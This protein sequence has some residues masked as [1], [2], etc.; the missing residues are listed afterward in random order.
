MKLNREIVSLESAIAQG[1][2]KEEY[3]L[4][5][6]ML[7]RSPTNVE[8]GIFAVMWSEHCSYKSSRKHLK[9]FPTEGSKVLQGP[10]ENAGII[11]IGDGRAVVFKME[12]HN[13]PSYIEPYQGAATGIGGILRDIFTMGARPVALMDFLR[14]GD[15][16]EPR[17][18]YLL[19]GVVAGIA[20][21]G[22]CVGIPTVGGDTF[23]HKT[24][25]GNN[26]VNVFCLGIV[27]T[28]EIYRGNATGTGNRVIYLGSKTGRDGIHGA[29]MASEEFSEATEEKRPTVQVGD[30]FTK[31]L[32][33]EACLEMM[34]ERLIEGIQDMGAAGLT[35]STFEMAYR[36]GGGLE[37]NLDL[38]PKREKEMT[39][40]ELMLS[41]SQ[42]RM[43]LVS[44]KQNV[45]KIL[46]IAEKWGLDACDI[47]F[48][49]DG[50][51]VKIKTDGKAVCDVD[52]R[53]ITDE[54]PIYNRPS[55]EPKDRVKGIYSKKDIEQPK[56]LNK[57]LLTMLK[58][59]NFSS[60]EWL[61]SQYDHMV[62][63][64]T[65][66]LPGS[67][68]AILRIKGL[69]QGLA[70]TGDCNS[71]YCYLNP[72]E[73]S[74]I[75]VCEAARNISCQGGTPIGITDC[76]NFGNPE[77]P[78]IMWEFKE[79]IRGISET[80]K[81]FET[82]VVSGNVSFYNET[83]G[84]GIYP[85]PMIGMVGVVDDLSCVN[86]QWFKNDGD[87]V[88]LIGDIS[89]EK[90]LTQSEYLRI[91][92][93]VENFSVPY[94]DILKE[95]RLCDCVL[96]LNKSKLLNSAHDCSDGGLLIALTE[97]CINPYGY[98][99][100]VKV[101]HEYNSR[102]DI[103]LFSEEQSRI[104][105]SFDRANKDKVEAICNKFE[106]PLNVIGEVGGKKLKFSEYIDTSL[107]DLEDARNYFFNNL[108][109]EK[110]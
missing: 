42:E 87:T 108:N 17:T 70:L 60:K 82:P 6:R 69:K 62:G 28:D 13:H 68:A 53:F 4:I 61:Y 2:T 67:D 101:K 110:K 37:V 20:G 56:E 84:K 81:I 55:K 11:D 96:K 1:L 59:P 93:N 22:N 8:L 47:G 21:Y 49:T 9:T 54:A 27:K 91:I 65:T 12:S 77:N 86:N 94:V 15:I 100:G 3:N 80:C 19:D 58:D 78:E 14:F 52:A 34:K 18:S 26:L 92:H 79:S 30:P 35:C 5:Q 88:A 83:N 72:Y 31:K 50:T 33:L 41:E 40:Y 109:K 44:R 63:T 64:D 85:T 29:T 102:A 46:S 43:L 107:K 103:H 99:R 73:G 98:N 105:I 90:V 57:T 36:G 95:K 74:K 66:V 106:M 71:H 24:Y 89:D 104:L 75:A 48:V 10:G 23:F 25:N 51:K 32:L 16:S 39:P 76:L 97:S 7:G 45:N 38:V